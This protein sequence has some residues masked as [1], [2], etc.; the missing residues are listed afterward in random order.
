M[1]KQTEKPNSKDVHLHTLEFLKEH[2]PN[3]YLSDVQEKTENRYSDSLIHQ[4]KAGKK[5]NSDI[6]LALVELANMNK[7]KK[8]KIAEI[9][10]Y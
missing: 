8:E 2:L 3:K 5:N 10:N 1:L 9:I 7:E 4:V 6:L